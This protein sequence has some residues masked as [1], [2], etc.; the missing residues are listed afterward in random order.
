MIKTESTGR[1]YK[2]TVRILKVMR[3]NLIVLSKI[4]EE[5]ASSFFIESLVY[6]V[7]N[8]HF[9][10]CNYTQT[11]KNVITKLYN[12]MGDLAVTNKY[13]EVSGYKW[14]FGSG[15]KRPPANGREFMLN[16]W[17]YAEFK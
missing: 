16:C 2:R 11:L 10:V 15:G 4:S 3:N 14:L 1:M 5:L 7:P 9:V 17:Q 8:D 12:D 6:N 13:V